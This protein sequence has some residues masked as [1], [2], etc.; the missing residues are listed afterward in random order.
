MALHAYLLISSAEL[1]EASDVRGMMLLPAR[2]AA[3][4][5]IG[6]LRTLLR[7]EDRDSA[8][9]SPVSSQP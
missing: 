5:L 8:P 9:N 1:W 2:A 7:D 4:S 6:P 3:G